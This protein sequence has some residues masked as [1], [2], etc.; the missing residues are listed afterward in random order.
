MGWKLGNA[1]GMCAESMS[2][3]IITKGIKAPPI[4]MASTAMCVHLTSLKKP[5][6]E[7]AHVEGATGVDFGGGGGGLV[8]AWAGCYVANATLMVKN[9]FSLRAR[10]SGAISSSLES[11]FPYSFWWPKV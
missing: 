5:C 6:W 8:G 3:V 11:R 4:I 7:W 1:L 9:T 2:A 10:A